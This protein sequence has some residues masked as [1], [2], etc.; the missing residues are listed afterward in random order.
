M[1]PAHVP[2]MHLLGNTHVLPPLLL[3]L[4]SERRA[5]RTVDPGR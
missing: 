1:F 2:G 4:V 3:P 5:A